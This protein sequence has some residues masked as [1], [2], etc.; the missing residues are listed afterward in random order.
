MKNTT[1]KERYHHGDLRA[2]LI[3]ASLAIIAK[4][5]AEAL[6]LRSA[7]REA[8]VSHAAPYAHFED[9][10]DL[11]AAVKDEGF[12][13]LFQ[14]LGDAL[15]ALPKDPTARVEAIARVYLS[16]AAEQ[17]AKYTVMFRRPLTKDPRPEYTYIQTGREMFHLLSLEFGAMALAK[18][19]KPAFDPLLITMCSW[20]TLHG[21]CSLWNDGPMMQ[22][23]PPG[24]QY[25]D[26]AKQFVSYVLQS[27]ARA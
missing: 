27:V 15:A 24:T 16:F 1:K 9:K 20:S 2:A 25:A 6:T 10:E 21:L 11:V 18:N 22:M 26:L 19:A 3:E 8:G 5:G 14:L 13:E 12:R 7:A 17:P 4:E 23:A